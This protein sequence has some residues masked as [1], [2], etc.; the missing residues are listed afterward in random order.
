MAKKVFK[1]EFDKRFD[2]FEVD[3]NKE[4]DLKVDL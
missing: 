3:I 2:D 4:L 1:E